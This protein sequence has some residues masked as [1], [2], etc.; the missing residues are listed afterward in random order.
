M[1]AAGG[2][3]ICPRLEILIHHRAVELRQEPCVGTVSRLLT[4]E[5]RH[6]LACLAVRRVDR[7]AAH[8]LK[9]HLLQPLA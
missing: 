9:R 3:A 6:R 4:L 5:R 7:T 2:E 1:K 8:I